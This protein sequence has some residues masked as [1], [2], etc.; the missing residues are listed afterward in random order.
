MKDN[1]TRRELKEQY[2]EQKRLGG[3]FAIRNTVKNRLL[4]DATVDLQSRKNRFDFSMQM[5]SCIDLKLQKDWEVQGG[6]GFVF[7][8][9]E[10]LAKKE[11]QSEAEFKDDIK[12]LK[13]IWLEKLAGENLY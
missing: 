3:V 8:V 6:E 4:L 13:E 2:K 1:E 5:G 9:L 12:L 11:T 7:E 10:E